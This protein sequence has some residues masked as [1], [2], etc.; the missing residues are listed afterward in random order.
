MGP[1]DLVEDIAIAY[2]YNNFEPQIPE[3]Y[4][5]AKSIEDYAKIDETIRGVWVF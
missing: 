4:T 5:E 1:I 2:G 3:I